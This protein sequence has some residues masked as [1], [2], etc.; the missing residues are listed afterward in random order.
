MRRAS[1][2]AVLLLSTAAGAWAASPPPLRVLFVGNSLTYTNDLPAMFARIGALDGRRI[3]TG[4]AASPNFSLE[5]HLVSKETAK[6]LAGAWDVVVLQQGP[7]SLDSSRRGLIRDTRAIA[8]RIR[9]VG[10]AR[11]ALLMAWPDRSRLAALERVAES[12]RLA[13]EAVGGTFL[14][15]GLVLGSAL[16]KDARP[17]LLL[18]DGFHPGPAGTWLAAL[19]AYQGLVGPPP[20]SAWTPAGARRVAGPDARLTA[21]VLESLREIFAATV[22]R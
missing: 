9:A 5:D 19:A 12:Y 6:A 8:G 2:F 17:P 7:S 4:T 11:I 20:E 3:V 18:E 14:P 1:F 16:R 15:A 10:N 21:P 13:A 22:P